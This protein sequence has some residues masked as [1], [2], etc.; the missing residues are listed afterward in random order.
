MFSP[1]PYFTIIRPIN[2]FLAG[3]SLVIGILITMGYQILLDNLYVF[4]LGL[5]IVILISAGGFIINDIYDIEIDKINQPNRILPSGKISLTSAWIY[6]VILFIIGLLLSLYSLTIPVTFNLGIIPPIMVAIGIISLFLYAAI[7]KKLGLIGNLVIIALSTIP[8]FVGGLFV[9]D[10]SKA[11]FPVLIVLTV[12]Y[13]REIIKDVD[14]IKGDVAAS[15][16]I[17]NLPT[18]I[19]IK[20]TILVGKI[21]LF[22]TV[23]ITLLPF[24]TIYF[25]TFR[26]WGVVIVALT[27]DIICLY[28]ILFLT[29]NDEA[30]IAK[31]RKVKVY[32]K[33]G[34]FLGLVGLAFNS[35]TL[36]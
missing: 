4:S 24:T 25:S 19:G 36:I 17:I 28:S 23:L 12:Q 9:N 11:V 7:L 29:G 26:S 8:F 35:F 13:S 5:I 31:S 18:I 27:L 16:F 21:L 15:D 1:K 2:C 6:T 34:I 14:D 10:L 32:L 22:L 30:L 33:L 3:F 20:N